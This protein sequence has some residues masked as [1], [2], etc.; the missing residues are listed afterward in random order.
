MTIGID[1]ALF[2]KLK[3]ALIQ[4]FVDAANQNKQSSQIEFTSENIIVKRLAT[5]SSVIE[6]AISS[7]SSSYTSI[8]SGLSTSLASSSAVSG[9]PI[10]NYEV[11]AVGSSSSDSD[12][13]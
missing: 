4:M 1:L 7:D 8:S 3:N 5:G 9:F 13:E 6:G 2:V 11:S 10:I 12:S